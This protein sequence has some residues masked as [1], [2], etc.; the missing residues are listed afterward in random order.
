MTPGDFFQG[1]QVVEALLLASVSVAVWMS[2]QSRGFVRLQVLNHVSSSFAVD[3]ISTSRS[4]DFASKK[5][6]INTSRGEQELPVRQETLHLRETNVVL[7]G[8]EL[9]TQKC[10]LSWKNDAVNFKSVSRVKN[11]IFAEKHFFKTNKKTSE[12]KK[13]GLQ[14][15]LPRRLKKNDFLKGNGT[16]KR[17]AIEAKKIKKR[18]KK[19][20]TKNLAP[21]PWR[22]HSALQASYLKCEHSGGCQ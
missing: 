1:E 21:E 20:E 14:G 22:S 7:R 16:R 10:R 3:V 5:R 15:Y 19:G 18:K 13:R 4:C 9:V 8:H 12:K 11:E 2:I 6:E 17:A